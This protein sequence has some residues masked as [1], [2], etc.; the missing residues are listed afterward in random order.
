MDVLLTKI[1]EIYLGV[2]SLLFLK[3]IIGVRTPNLDQRLY[4]MCRSRIS[5]F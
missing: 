5:K 4:D 2:K 1:Q 3:L